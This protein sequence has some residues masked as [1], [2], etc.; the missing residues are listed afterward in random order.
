MQPCDFKHGYLQTTVLG[1]RSSFWF[2]F[3]RQSTVKKTAENDLIRQVCFLQKS[4][5][6]VQRAQATLAW[7]DGKGSCIYS[8]WKFR[9]YQDNPDFWVLEMNT[10]AQSSYNVSGS[11]P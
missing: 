4:L 6:A 3:L 7:R 8:T 11:A 2:C 9:I 5:K 10:M 1:V